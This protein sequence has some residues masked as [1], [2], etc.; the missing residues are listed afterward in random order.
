VTLSGTVANFSKAFNVELL[1]YEHPGGSY[2]GRTGLIHIPSELDGIVTAV[3]AST[4]V[5]KR[6]RIF[7]RI[8]R[9]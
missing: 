8:A 5:R 3:L 9:P 7:A 1:N 2:R 4:T 6:G